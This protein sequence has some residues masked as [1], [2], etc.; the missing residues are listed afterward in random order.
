MTNLFR[1]G[2]GYDVHQLV[3]NRPLIL[4]GI[5]IDHPTG[6]LGHSDADVLTHTI[7]DAILGALNLGT[8]GDLFPD[9]DPA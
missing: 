2:C 6:L 4:G 9:T 5:T 7:M 1:I 3:A 8:I